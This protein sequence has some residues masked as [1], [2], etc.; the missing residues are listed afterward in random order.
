MVGTGLRRVVNRSER[1]LGAGR[2]AGEQTSAKGRLRRAERRIRWFG[3]P[4]GQKIHLKGQF[5]VP[6]GSVSH[7]TWDN[8]GINPARRYWVLGF[9]FY[10]ERGKGRAT[11]DGP[12][13]QAL[14]R[15]GIGMYVLYYA[16]SLY[17]QLGGGG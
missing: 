8:L 13:Q 4:N 3:L 2:S 9:L 6:R 17:C 15:Q 14:A 7:G 16:V 5:F 12:A 1:V 10:W 11:G